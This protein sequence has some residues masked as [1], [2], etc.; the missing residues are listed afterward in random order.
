MIDVTFL[1]LIYFLVTQVLAQPEDRLSPNLQTRQEQATGQVSD[2]QTQIV[3]VLRLAGQPTY[4][5][6]SRTMTDRQSLRTALEGLPKGEGVIIEVA[7][8]VPVEF[9]FAAIQIARDVGF[10]QVTYVPQ[11]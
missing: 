7:N 3:E 1:L 6:G 4:R 5:V 9:A 10:E 8:S 11:E 2:F